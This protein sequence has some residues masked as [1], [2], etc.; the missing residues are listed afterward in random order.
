MGLR[1]FLGRWLAS[2]DDRSVWGNFWFEPVGL[3][4]LAG[5]RV[6]AAAAMTLPTV[7]ACVRVLAESF[8]V[9]PFVLYRQGERRQK[10]TDH[11]LQRLFCRAPNRFQTPFEWRLML[12]GHLALRGNALTP[13]TI[14]DTGE[15][16]FSNCSAT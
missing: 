15:P 8:A 6:T 13:L 2:G 10:V 1:S 12:M 11:W 3:R 16:S 9:M 14:V 5:A 4:T 7:F